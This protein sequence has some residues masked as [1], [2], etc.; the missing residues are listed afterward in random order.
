MA[1]RNSHAEEK[2]FQEGAGS[3]AGG[4][5]ALWGSAERALLMIEG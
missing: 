4:R 3:C 5:P 1:A 2:I